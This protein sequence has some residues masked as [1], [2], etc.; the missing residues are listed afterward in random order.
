VLG[1]GLGLEILAATALLC[2]TAYAIALVLAT[3]S[4][5]GWRR[6]QRIALRLGAPIALCAALAL[7]LGHV[8]PDP[9]LR[10]TALVL[11]LYVLGIAPLLPGVLRG[12]RQARR[13]GRASAS[14]A[15]RLEVKRSRT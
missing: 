10:E 4:V 7:L 5:T 11:G 2:R 15:S 6:R 1:L 12:M 9:D 3:R 8:F 13:L 14:A